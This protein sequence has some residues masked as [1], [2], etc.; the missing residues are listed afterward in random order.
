MS[1]ARWALRRGGPGYPPGL[2]EL[3]DAPQWL[4]GAG[5][6]GA[7]EGL[8]P[9]AAVCVVGARRASAHGCRVASELAAGVASAGVTVVS[10]MAF[11]ID[12]AAHRGALD[13]GGVTVAVL[14]GGA[15]VPY[16]PSAA[17][18][19]RRILASGA[20]VSEAPAG[21]RPGRWRFP[22]RNRL[23]AAMCAITVVVEASVRSG[24]RHT[25]DAAIELGRCVAAVPGDVRS[26]LK[27]GP[28]ELL[29]DGA[30]LVRDAQDVLDELLG[31]GATSVRRT[32]PEVDASAARVLDLLARGAATPDAVAIGSG[33][34]ARSLAVELARLELAGYLSVDPSGR[35]ARTGLEPP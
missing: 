16:P 2:A 15:D 17:G 33:L 35:L 26:P 5:D 4:R 25:A 11:G 27:A 12:S 28:H 30:L 18:L 9:R 3:A 34:D 20:A 1:A 6:R 22:A 31:V 32:G 19:Y 8:E 23:M 7:V 21:L 13:A 29:R 10:G 24:S 14:A